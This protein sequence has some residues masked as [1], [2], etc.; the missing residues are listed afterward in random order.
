MTSLLL[1][2]HVKDNAHRFFYN[3][4][5]C[6][7]K[8]VYTLYGC[9]TAAVSRFTAAYSSQ[10]HPGEFL[11]Y[12]YVGVSLEIVGHC[13]DEWGELASHHRSLPVPDPKAGHLVSFNCALSI[14]SHWGWQG[15]MCLHWF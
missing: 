9:S 1:R 13:W 12:K 10:C 14:L 4:P 15:F 11:L 2:I 7:H 3:E 8:I 5:Y 6:D